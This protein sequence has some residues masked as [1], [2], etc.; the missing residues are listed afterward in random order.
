M[1]K[2]L[3]FLMLV[4]FAGAGLFALHRMGEADRKEPFTAPPAST[5]S[6]GPQ[7][8]FATPAPSRHGPANAM[9]IRPALAADAPLAFDY[10]DKPLLADGTFQVQWNF[11]ASSQLRL[12]DVMKVRLPFAA[13]PYTAIVLEDTS[14]NGTRRL[15]GRLQDDQNIDSW[16][17]S[18]TM[19]SDGQYVTANFTTATGSFSLD[20]TPRG[21]HLRSTAVDEAWLHDDDVH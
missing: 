4:L 16:P 21:G 19:S 10:T 12:G 5:G 14:S 20:A 6:A 18:M 15:S 3:A 7:A 2:P 8:A 1:K 17:F 11:E 9:Q 13:E